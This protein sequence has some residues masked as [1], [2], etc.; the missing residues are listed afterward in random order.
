MQGRPEKL[1]GHV[2]LE[3]GRLSRAQHRGAK[4]QS[5]S[6][7]MQLSQYYF[8]SMAALCR[9]RL[10]NPVPQQGPRTGQCLRAGT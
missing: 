6:V 7:L 10:D 1:T 8:Q 4:R 9:Q 3:Q 5:R 2:C